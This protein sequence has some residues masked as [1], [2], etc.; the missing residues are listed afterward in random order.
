M[1]ARTRLIVFVA[2]FLLLYGGLQ[3]ATGL[4]RW[5]IDD[6]TVPLAAWAIN[7]TGVSPVPV[8][9][10]GSRL[11]ASGGGLNVLQGCEGLDL[12]CLWIAAVS[13][14]PFTWRARLLALTLGSA[15]VVALNQIRLVSLYQLYRQHR[16][17][18]DDAHGLWWPLALVV[19]VWALYSLWQRASGT[20]WVTTAQAATP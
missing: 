6:L 18:F 14:G 5:F 8:H 9:A 16:A 12:L 3:F 15:V 17:W 7:T 2:V 4:Q 1:S 20:P 13:A 10:N 11:V 19:L